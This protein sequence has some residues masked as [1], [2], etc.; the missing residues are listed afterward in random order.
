MGPDLAFEKWTQSVKILLLTFVTMA[1]MYKRERLQA[2]I[3]IIVVS[4]GYFGAKGGLFTI[5]GGGTSH[6]W[7]PPGSFIAA[8]N[9]PAMALA[10]VMPRVG[11]LQSRTDHTR[12]LLGPSGLN[13]H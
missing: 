1:L 10:M 12:F 7:G 8:N 3:R 11:S 13:H 4:L 6:V 5:V 9:A 2:L